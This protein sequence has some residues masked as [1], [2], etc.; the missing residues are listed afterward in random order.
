MATAAPEV[1]AKAPLTRINWAA[2]LNLGIPAARCHQIMMDVITEYNSPTDGLI[3]GMST[4][5]AA[6]E[7]R[8]A[9][10]E[11]IAN[12]KISLTDV[13]SQKIHRAE[14]A[15]YAI[16]RIANSIVKQLSYAALL[17]S[18]DEE[19]KRLDIPHIHAGD[20]IDALSTAPLFRD[21]PSYKNWKEEMRVAEEASAARKARAEIEKAAGRPAAA[22]AK[23]Q[24]APF[25]TYVKKIVHE[26][27]NSA[28]QFKVVGKDAAKP[29]SKPRLRG[30]LRRHISAIVVDFCRTITKTAITILNG[31]GKAHTVNGKHII[32]AVEAIMV[33]A[34]VDDVARRRIIKAAEDCVTLHTQVRKEREVEKERVKAAAADD[35]AASAASD[36]P[37]EDDGADV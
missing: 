7:K 19:K 3:E 29:P 16:A 11:T 28:A 22:A 26:V 14:S 27:I 15:Q 12:L 20:K 24:R 30:L 9:A 1:P 21:L 25:E 33:N 2:K 5:I 37:V 36:A 17:T 13:K 31:M 34:N 32:L 6:L 18:A 8:G 4:K 35:A 10:P 23:E